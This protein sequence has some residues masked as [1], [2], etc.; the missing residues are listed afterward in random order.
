MRDTDFTTS[1]AIFEKTNNWFLV[2]EIVAAF[3][4]FAP[5]F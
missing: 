2:G 5:K 4:S 3:G 1:L